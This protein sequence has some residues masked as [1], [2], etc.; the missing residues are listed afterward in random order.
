M[1][2]QTPTTLVAPRRSR[3]APRFTDR[4][5]FDHEHE[6]GGDRALAVVG[7]ELC[8]ERAVARRADLHVQVRR[9]AGVTTG[10]HGLVAKGAVGAGPLRRAQLVVILA[11][12]VG[13]PPLE[14]RTPEPRARARRACRRARACPASSA[15]MPSAAPPPERSPRARGRAPARREPCTHGSIA[16]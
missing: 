14:L 16:R 3:G 1:A 11:A 8:D 7:V 12:P 5:L 6:V 15:R 4:L 9:A 13:R 2:P 10:R